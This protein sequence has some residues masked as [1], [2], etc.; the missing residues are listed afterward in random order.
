VWAV[1]RG[2]RLLTDGV[3]PVVADRK[4][5]IA[6]SAAIEETREA[7]D[8]VVDSIGF[9]ADDARQDSAVF[10]NRAAHLVFVWTD[11]LYGRPRPWKI[12]VS[13]DRLKTDLA[14]G[15]GKRDAE[16]VLLESTGPMRVTVLRPCYICGPGSQ[17]GC[18]PDHGRDPQLLDKINDEAGREGTLSTATGVR[19]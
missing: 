15:R 11:F 17:L 4:D 1:T 13:F 2:Q 16:R 3:T 14:N 10:S 5:A 19:V 18:P 6:F 12:D 9:F 8:L 7:S